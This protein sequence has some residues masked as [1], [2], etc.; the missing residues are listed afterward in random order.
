MPEGRPKVSLIHK[1]SHLKLTHNFSHDLVG[2]VNLNLSPFSALSSK[3][4]V[5]LTEESWALKQVRVLLLQL[6][7]NRVK[8]V[9]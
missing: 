6:L 3:V 2:V 5:D 1:R 7:Q 9:I 4:R 8:V